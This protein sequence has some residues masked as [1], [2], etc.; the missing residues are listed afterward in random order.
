MKPQTDL[1]YNPDAKCYRCG[2]AINH[3]TEQW[4]CD[5]G[6]T[7]ADKCGAPT[8]TKKQTPCEGAQGH[9]GPHWHWTKQ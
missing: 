4:W 7:T 8:A 9:A 6:P 2:M 3:H 5:G 1:P